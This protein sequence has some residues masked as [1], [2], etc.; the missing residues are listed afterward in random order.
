MI[1]QKVQYIKKD[2]TP[3]EMNFAKLSEAIEAGVVSLKGGKERK[4]RPGLEPVW[5]LDKKAIRM[6][7]WK[8]VFFWD[9]NVT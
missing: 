1:K 3:R 6:I 4:L 7:D 9:K 8:T 5:D 2:G